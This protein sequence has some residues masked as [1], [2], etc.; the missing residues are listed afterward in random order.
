MTFSC[1]SATHLGPEAFRFDKNTEA[2]SVRQNE[3]YYILRPETIETWFYMWRLTKEPKYR[4]W[5]WDVVQV[6]VCATSLSILCG[7]RYP[8]LCFLSELKVAFPVAIEFSLHCFPRRCFFRPSRS[9]AARRA[10][11]RASGTCTK[12]TP[13]KTMCSRASS[14]LRLS[15]IFTCFSQKTI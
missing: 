8:A 1:V 12:Q 6:C 13:Q 2:K 4:E 10:V 9:T 3:K 7:T 14:S 5:G 11:T 15:S